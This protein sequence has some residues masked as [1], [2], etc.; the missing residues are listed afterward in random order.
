M[1]DRGLLR[2][3]VN[4]EIFRTVEQLDD[5]LC[6][7]CSVTQQP[8]VTQRLFGTPKLALLFA[9]L[10]GELD[11]EFSVT[12]PLILRKRQDTRHIIAFRRF[13]LFGEI[14]NG[15]ASVGITL[16]LAASFSKDN[17]ESEGGRP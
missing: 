10:V 14:T 16:A 12:V 8:Q 11:E 4:A 15:M 13:F 7:I 2:N 5:D 17:S 9:Q 6:P 1:G 3:V